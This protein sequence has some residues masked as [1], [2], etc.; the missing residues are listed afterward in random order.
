MSKSGAFRGELIQ[1]RRIPIYKNYLSINVYV[2]WK[3]IKDIK[4]KL[5]KNFS[6]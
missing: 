2:E 5:W 3:Y 1:N 4:G 6:L